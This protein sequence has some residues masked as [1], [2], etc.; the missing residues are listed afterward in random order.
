MRRSWPS[1]AVSRWL[2]CL[3]WVTSSSMRL[4]CSRTCST[5]ADQLFALA[6]VALLRA[7]GDLLAGGHGLQPAV[8][9]LVQLLVQRLDLL[10]GRQHFGLQ[11]LL[12]RGQRDAGAFALIVAVQI[13]GAIG[14]FGGA[15]AAAAVGRRD[16]GSGA[17]LPSGA[18]APAPCVASRSM[19]SRSSIRPALSWSCQEMIALKVSGLSHRPPII[20]SRPAS[21]RLAMAISP[22]RDSSSTLP[23]SRRYIRTG[24]SVRPRLASST[25]PVWLFLLRLPRSFRP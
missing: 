25:L 7:R 3:S 8:L 17:T 18:G 14:W 11:L 21:M 15:V 1:S 4:L 12:Q 19:M 9:H 24:S 10:E 23:I 2:S 22:S 5:F 20:M 13:I 6:L 16:R